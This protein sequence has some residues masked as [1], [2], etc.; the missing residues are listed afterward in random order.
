[1]VLGR[2][3]SLAYRI[4]KPKLQF[5]LRMTQN[6]NTSVLLSLKLTRALTL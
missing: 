1:M 6:V 2:H 4:I 3:L 5:K